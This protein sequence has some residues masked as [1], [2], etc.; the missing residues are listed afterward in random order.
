MEDVVQRGGQQEQRGARVQNRLVSALRMKRR[1]RRDGGHFFRAESQLGQRNRIERGVLH[2][3]P[4]DIAGH[5]RGVDGSQGKNALFLA[6]TEAELVLVAVFRV[7]GVEIIQNRVVARG[8]A[9]Q[10]RIRQAKQTVGVAIPGALL[11]S[12]RQSRHRESRH[13]AECCG[14]IGTRSIVVAN[15]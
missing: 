15:Q 9:V 6:Q 11:F 13:D 10:V 7:A 12:I 8:G 5:Q 2:V 14:D 4:V 3:D 1:V